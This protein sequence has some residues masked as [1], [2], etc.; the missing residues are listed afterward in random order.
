MRSTG[1]PEAYPVTGSVATA[2]AAL[3]PTILPQVK[4]G[5]V[6]IEHP[7][8]VMAVDAA[9]G[10]GPRLL[11]AA[12]RRSARC[13]MDGPA[14]TLQTPSDPSYIVYVHECP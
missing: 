13:L 10:E 3:L 12:M 7:S 6:R 8:G 1:R 5:P 11:R 9:V 4:P 14:E 2:A